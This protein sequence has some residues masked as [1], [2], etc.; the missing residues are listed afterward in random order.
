MKL[1]KNIQ[2][3]LDYEEETHFTYKNCVYV[4]VQYN[5]DYIALYKTDVNDYAINDLSLVCLYSV[6]SKKP[7]I[8][9]DRDFLD[10]YSEH[11]YYRTMLKSVKSLIKQEF[12]DLSNFITED[13]SLLL[14]QDLKDKAKELFLNS[15]EP[16]FQLPTMISLR[17][18]TLDDYIQIAEDSSEYAYNLVEKYLTE[19]SELITE[20]QEYLALKELLED[21]YETFP[22]EFLIQKEFIKI[23]SNSSYKQLRLMV[24]R[25]D[26]S[27]EELV[28]K[29]SSNFY[30]SYP[31]YAIKKILHGRSVL[32]ERA[33]SDL[34]KYQLS[35]EWNLEKASQ[36]VS[37][38]NFIICLSPKLLDSEN[39]VLEGCKLSFEFYKGA[40]TRLKND[41]SFIKKI[42]ELCQISEK[43]EEL[44]FLLPE[45]WQKDVDFCIQLIE[46]FKAEIFNCFEEEIQKNH[47]VF[48]T[49]MNEF[50]ADKNMSILYS[51]NFS[52]EILADDCN[53][54][55]FVSKMKTVKDVE[56][57]KEFLKYIKDETLA[58]KQISTK[59]YEERF[60]KLSEEFRFNKNFVHDYLDNI[61]YMNKFS[62]KAETF[63][64]NILDYLSEDELDDWS[65]I[66]RIL[67]YMDLKYSN[68]RLPR[69]YLNEE[70][71]E[72]K[73]KID[74]Q[75]IAY[76]P[77][78][79][80]RKVIEKCYG[81]SM[82]FYYSTV[83]NSVPENEEFL[84]KLAKLNPKQVGYMKLYSKDFIFELVKTNVEAYRYL[85]CEQLN[86][87]LIEYVKDKIFVLDVLP[88]KSKHNASYHPINDKE[89]VLK[90]FELAPNEYKEFLLGYIPKATKMIDDY[91]LLDD[92]EVV[93][94][95][96]E[97]GYSNVHSVLQ[98]KDLPIWKD[99]NLAKKLCVWDVS[100]FP[101]FKKEAMK[102][103][104]II[105]SLYEELSKEDKT[106]LLK[107]LPKYIQEKL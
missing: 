102:D 98:P 83:K 29:N 22:T 51:G 81:D 94:A 63:T 67:A 79:I 34:E 15:K 55:C 90:Q 60:K 18:I 35:E 70:L 65:L 97:K 76:F 52:R 27:I 37:L 14:R 77:K 3:F 17:K 64:A 10:D 104:D 99:I 44:Y 2:F 56:W 103:F 38:N 89:F 26:G 42:F 9:F 82:L 54:D 61:E 91:S 13:K 4:K 6:I 53:Y 40:S 66:K 62:S 46:T 31:F 88:E 48:Q 20:F 24:E 5:T 28:I 68:T 30:A 39:F 87:D 92:E 7:I 75:Q 100:L 73:A 25:S 47:K 84:L 101:Y 41:I 23:A 93:K 105:K 16:E 78:D 33:F 49:F 71:A 11:M 45:K 36:L 74:P 12:N 19:H 69:K 50:D 86:T 59:F 43:A 32:Y 57:P 21:C 95:A 96:I 58:L 80:Q 107:F 8:F 85:T 72:L 106:T 1:E